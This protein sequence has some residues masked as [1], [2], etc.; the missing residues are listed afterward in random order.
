[1]KIMLFNTLFY[2]NI[3][4]GAEKSVQIL[5]EELADLGHQVVVVSTA[6]QDEVKFFDKIKAY[7]IHHHNIYWGGM[8]RTE[9]RLK[10]MMWHILD[11]FNPAVYKALARIVRLEKPDII[12]TNMMSGFSSAP[13]IVAKKFN[14]P[15]VHTLRE[16]HLLCLRMSMFKKDHNCTHQCFSCSLATAP[17]KYL[18]N[19][20][21]VTHVAG[22]SDFII[23]RHQELDYFKKTP[24]TRIFNGFNGT[25]IKEPALR[26]K[27]S[28]LRI[29]YLGRI[30][31]PKGAAHVLEA[32]KNMDG[33]EL[34]LGGEVLDDEIKDGIAHGIYPDHIKFLGF[35]KPEQTMDGFDLLIVPS[36]WYE[37]FGRVVIEAYQ[38]GK[39]VIASNHG[40]LPE[41]VL[42]GQTGFLY[43]P[44]NPTDLPKLL[45]MLIDTPE[46]LATVQEK[47][48]KHLDQFE[49]KSLAR[50]YGRIYEKAAGKCQQH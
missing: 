4:G 36:L 33:V 43:D 42:E 7:Y 49:N 20:S 50:E 44:D 24:C 47:I 21:Y 18:T 5:A 46:C 48:Y 35:I 37:P 29:L 10:I 6:E 31:K 3:F 8:P 11:I 27:G 39:P 12:H 28:P 13:W 2:P 19:H 17:K 15:V 16:Y 38:H 45:Q 22:L 32:V 40:G 26:E 30:D 23:N 25:D 1:M 9:N 14:I 41:I 34:H